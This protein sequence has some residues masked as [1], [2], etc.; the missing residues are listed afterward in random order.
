METSPDVRL[1]TVVRGDVY[2]LQTLGLKIQI[3]WRSMQRDEKE[4]TSAQPGVLIAIGSPALTHFARTHASLFEEFSSRGWPQG[5]GFL[6]RGTAAS[7]V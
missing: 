7:S 3:C 5:T 4:V 1:L 6:V 2:L